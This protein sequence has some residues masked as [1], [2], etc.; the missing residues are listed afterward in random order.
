MW[1]F[2][3]ITSYKL[4]FRALPTIGFLFSNLLFFF[5]L[6]NTA[7][8]ILVPQPGIKPGLLTMEER[9]PN[10]WTTR[11]FFTLWCLPPGDTHQFT[12]HRM[13][14]A[15]LPTPHRSSLTCSIGSSPPPGR[16]SLENS[17]RFCALQEIQRLL[18]Q[19]IFSLKTKNTNNYNVT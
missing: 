18:S 10:H 9:N 16:A 6:C 12:M 2:T 1:T 17:A 13:H 14:T 19:G 7:C 8:R 4:N 5:F 3:T 11:K 15:S